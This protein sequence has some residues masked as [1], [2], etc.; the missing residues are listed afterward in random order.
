MKKIVELVVPCYNEQ[1]VLNLFIDTCKEI[2]TIADEY[3]FLYLLVDDGS[4][5]DTYL[6]MKELHEANENINYI[7]LSRNFGKEAAIYAGLQHAQGDYIVVMDADLQDPP[8]LIPTMIEC[9]ENDGYDMV[10]TR[11]VTRKGEP[12][13]R[14]LF[15]RMFYKLINSI[16]KVEMVDGARD[17]RMMTRQATNAVLELSEYNRYSKGIFSWIG[18]KTKWLEYENQVRAAGETKWSFGKLLVYALDGIT[19]FSTVPLMISTF[20][21]FVISAIAVIS[22]VVVFIKTVFFGDPTSG[23][24]SMIIII[25]FLGGVQMISVGILGQYLAKTYLEVKRRPIY[26]KKESTVEK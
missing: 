7:T 3:S 18:F 11:R 15:A 20:L 25:L 14:S 17:Y 24:P 1:E 23:W 6:I 16:S 5:D 21:G 2:E 10:S 19:A 8:S 13:I 4:S 9:I 22:I 26:I 12:P